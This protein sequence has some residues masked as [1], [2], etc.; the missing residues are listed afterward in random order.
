[1]KLLE[2]DRAI[3]ETIDDEISDQEVMESV[4]D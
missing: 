2:I 4:A 3:F 1:M